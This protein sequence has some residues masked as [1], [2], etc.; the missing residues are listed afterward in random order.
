[1]KDGGNL[2]GMDLLDRWKDKGDEDLI[3]GWVLDCDLCSV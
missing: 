1:M 3:E 2:K